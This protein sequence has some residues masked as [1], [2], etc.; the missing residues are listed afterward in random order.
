MATLGGL[1]HSHTLFVEDDGT[2]VRFYIPPGPLKRQLYQLIIHGGGEMCR[3]QQP[4]ALLLSTPGSAQGAQYVS[5]AYVMDCVRKGELLDVDDY[6]LDGSHGR[7]R[8]SKGMK[9][10]EREGESSHGSDGKEQVKVGEGPEEEDELSDLGELVIE[11]GLEEDEQESDTVKIKKE[12]KMDCSEAQKIGSLKSARI[13]QT[14]RNPFTEEEDVAILVYVRDNAPH[15]GT[16]TGIALWKEMEQRR[17]LKRTW[18]AIKDRYIKHLKGK[19]GYRLP[20]SAASRSHDPSEDESPQPITK[21]S[22]TNTS[23]PWTKR[24]GNIGRTSEKLGTALPMEKSS[25]KARAEQSDAVES[26]SINFPLEKRGQHVTKGVVRRSEGEKKSSDMSKGAVSATSK[27]DQEDGGDLHI[28]E[29]ANMEFEVDDTPEIELPKRSLSLR[30]FVMGEDPPSSQSQ[31][32]V[33]EVSSSP[34]DSE[35]EGLQEALLGMMSEFKLRLRDVTQAL[36][37]N[38][39]ELSATRHFLRTGSRPDGFPIWI[40]K[41]DLDLQKADAETQ[42]RLI[43]KYGSDNVAKRVAFLAS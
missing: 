34:E 17:V 39:G 2:P 28:F 10:D 3:L 35:S 32:Q 16:V 4:G 7:K 21:K 25:T 27:E 8:Q 18:Q 14:G 19:Q 20:L 36:L 38:N 41:D 6:R 31:T 24:P 43:Q 26:T 22:R 11:E 42:K 30:E 5:T 23:T 12:N 33:D 9:Q 1:T 40:R 15:R 29:I 13:H 37:K